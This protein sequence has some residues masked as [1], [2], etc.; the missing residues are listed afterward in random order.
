MIAILV[1]H[2]SRSCILQHLN[3]FVPTLS[4]KQIDETENICSKVIEVTR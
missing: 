3:Y 2:R 4:L 1:E